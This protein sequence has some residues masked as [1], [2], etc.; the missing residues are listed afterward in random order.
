M[1]LCHTSKSNSA[2][3]WSPDPQRWRFIPVWPLTSWPT[4]LTFHPSV[5]FDLLTHKNDI[6]S[7]CDLDLW[8]PDPQ[9]W[10]FIPVWPLTSWPT[11]MA[12]HPSVTL[13]FDLL[14]NKGQRWRFIPVWPLTS[15][16]TKVTFHPTCASLQQNQFVSEITFTSQFDN[17]Q[18]DR[19]KDGQ[20]AMWDNYGFS[21]GTKRSTIRQISIT[22][23][24]P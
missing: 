4:K 13:T 21:G 11:K 20:T 15:W 14:T 9:R 3:L 17:V 22:L 8:P 6:S 12:F 10:R 24:F 2:L 7:Q 16:P 18:T 1:G 19:Q 23:H 5:T